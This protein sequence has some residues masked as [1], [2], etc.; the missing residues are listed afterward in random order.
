M[1]VV[2]LRGSDRVALVDDQFFADVIRLDW[3]IQ[4]G[5]G[6]IRYAVCTRAG[7]Q[8]GMHR[9]IAQIAGIESTLL[10]H[11]NRDGLDNRL[12][13][14][15]PCDHAQ[16]AWNVVRPVGASG[17]PGVYRN[18]NKWAVR[19]D[20]RGERLYLGSFADLN[21]AA[22]VAEQAQRQLRGEFYAPR[23]A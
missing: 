11:K 15:R 3:S 1:K 13:N 7:E 23:S 19:F 21:D 6:S 20:H 8:R 14:L 10:D 4:V 12:D 2:P 9:F 16:N 22:R 5:R 17:V 18:R